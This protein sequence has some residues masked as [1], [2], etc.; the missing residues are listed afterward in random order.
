MTRRIR[1]LSTLLAL[2][3]VA[4]V[5]AGCGSDSLH[6]GMG[7]DDKGTTHDAGQMGTGREADVMFTQEMIPHHQQAVE[8]ANLAL[9]PAYEAS[10]AVQ[11]LATRIKTAQAAEI[12]DMNAWLEEWGAEPVDGQMDHGDMDHDAMGMMS[13]A[14]M[15]ALAD[16]KGTA[17]DRLWL[18]GMIRHHDGA[19]MMASHID[20]RGDDPRVQDL[21]A[22]IEQSQTAEIAEMKQLLGK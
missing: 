14:D 5:A 22:A 7:H 13:A 2:V 4:A 19:L 8:M 15:T 1:L 6:S 21:S 9:D 17:F 20:A 10:P 18:E 3:V 12:A 16:A 11:D